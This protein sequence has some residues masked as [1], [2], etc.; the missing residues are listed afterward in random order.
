MA[1]TGDNPIK[2]GDADRLQ[3]RD[4]AKSL[5]NDIREVDASEGYV[6]GIVGP[7]GSGKTSIVNM[8]RESLEGDPS[9][10][11]ID[12]NPWIFS[13]SD[14][15]VQSF[16]RELAAQMRLK[17]D[18]LAEIASTVDAYSDLLSPV[19]AIPF[20]GA[21]FDRFRGAAKA[22][23][24]IQEKRKGSINEQ[25]DKLAKELAGLDKT[26]V[27]VI[28]DIDRL[29]TTEIRD[30]FKLVRLTASFPNVIYVLAFDRERVEEAL[31]QSGFDGRSYLEKIVQLG[32]DVPAV[33]DVVM[34]RQIGEALEAA[35]NDLDIPERFDQD[36]WPN[37]LMEIVRPLVKSMRDVRRY[38]AAVRSKA[39]ALGG[40]IELVDIMALEAIRVFLPDVFR[41]VVDGREGLTTA[42]SDYGS[43]YEDPRLKQQVQS[44]VEA[45]SA[46]PVVIKALIKRIFPAGQRHIENNSYG[47]T[48]LKTWLKARRV[49]HPDM[50]ALYLEQVANEGLK[51]FGLAEQAYAVLA[52][53]QELDSLLRSYDTDHLQDV[54][55]GLEAFEG[56]YLTESV[57]PASRVLL[58]LLPD[59]PER[60]QG[61][62]TFTDARLVV[63]RVVL[64]LMRQLSNP[65][66]VLAAVKEIL[67]AV[68]SLSSRAQLID[69]VGHREGVGHK[70]VD[71]VDARALERGL[72]AQLKGAAPEK[73]MGESELTRLLYG[74]KSWDGGTVIRVEPGQMDLFRALLLDARNVVTSQN[75]GNRAVRR[76]TRLHWDVLV[77]ILG[78]ESN[79]STA[80][81]GIRGEDDAELKEV[82]ELAD[83]YLSGWRPPQ[84]G[85]D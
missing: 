2:N 69:M 40:Q 11:V 21:W 61:V 64:R 80:I 63:V 76:T 7:W 16:F 81:D 31:S 55:A 9:L 44:V 72:I 5:A 8:V 3:R 36:A 56:D 32:I 53:E 15:L 20:I 41:V 34:L 17:G 57:V 60:P 78:D 58:N 65:S 48:W 39:R 33:P 29:E 70:L 77:E 47:S 68:Q 66:D 6:V 62:M 10:P 25:R 24:D 23:K 1:S 82:I 13:G 27:V 54:I 67:P 84:F 79:L 38:A 28:D 22:I 12:F 50:M 18:R 73:L 42:S 14:E 83:K 74:A 59:L 49:A 46:Y 52:D 85:D 43:Q 45:G 51:A 30:I 37:V 4:G 71:E 35:L 75:A 26:I 19:S